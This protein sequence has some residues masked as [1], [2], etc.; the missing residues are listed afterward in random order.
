MPLSVILCIST[1]DYAIDYPF[2]KEARKNLINRNKTKVHS[3]QR[4]A[5][6]FANLPG[7]ERT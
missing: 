7:P 6:L 4:S 1:S 2:T 5:Q 3:T